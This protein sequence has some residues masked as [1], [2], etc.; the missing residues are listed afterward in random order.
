MEEKSLRVTGASTTFFN[1]L[2][3]KI[4]NMFIPTRIG[5]NGMIIA[6][7]RSLLMKS[8]E[9][10]KINDKE[11]DILEKKYEEAYSQYLETLDKYVMDS[12]Y[13]KVKNNIASNFE[14]EALAKYY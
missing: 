14:R 2:T 10:Y 6:R 7:K 1:K 13:K 12:I 11:K 9:Q 8:F 4:S 3:K 5:I